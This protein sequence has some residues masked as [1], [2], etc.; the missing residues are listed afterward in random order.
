MKDKIEN[1][2]KDVLSRSGIDSGSFSVEYPS[3]I[4]NGDFSTNVAM[5]TAK[6][7]GEKPFEMAEKIKKLLNENL[8]NIQE[9][10]RIEVAMPGFINFFLKRD[11][12]SDSVLFIAENSDFGKIDLL[13]NKK[14]IVEY[15]DPNPFKE[16]HIGHLMS[17]T[18]GESISRIYQ[19]VGAD[20]KRACYQGDVGLHV[21]KAILGIKQNKSEIPNKEDD[22]KIWAKFLGKCYADGATLFEENDEVK[23]EIKKINKSVYERDDEDVNHFYD[24]GREKSLLYFE[25]IYKKLGTHFDFYFFESSSGPFGKEIVQEGLSRGIFEEGEEG[26]VVFRGEKYDPKLHTR[27]FINKEGLPT[28]EA[29]ELGL[30]KIKYEKFPYEESIVITGNEINEYFKVL[31]CAMGQLFP[32]LAEKTRHLSHGMLRLPEGKMS[33]RTGNVVTGESLLSLIGEKIEEKVKESGREDSATPEKIND[34]AVSALKYSVLKQGI[35]K[36]IV[37]D[38]E[39]SLSFDGDSGPYLLYSHARARSIIEKAESLGIDKKEI[40]LPNETFEIEKYLYRFPDMIKKAYEEKAPHVVLVYLVEMAREF[41]SFYGNFQ[42]VDPE[43][44][45]SSYKVSVTRAFANIIK[46]GL[47]VLGIKAPERM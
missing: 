34:I 11:F 44:T 3:L 27:V 35:G 7:S 8:A 40:V 31:L 29:K 21:A 23:E 33:S 28:Y 2:I 6:S 9:I 47:Y 43:D 39:K 36:D 24:L 17:N 20:V 1:W 22:I 18:I 45:S 15:T 10:D 42:I 13:K 41:N 4:T 14:V 16:F 30:S 19:Y 32:E 25:D 5:V 12:F 37:F 26:A 46:N 38:F